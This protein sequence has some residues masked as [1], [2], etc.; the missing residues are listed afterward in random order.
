M[1]KNERVDSQDSNSKQKEEPLN[2]DLKLKKIKQIVFP[3]DNNSRTDETVL[4]L[5]ANTPTEQNI[6]YS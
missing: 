6:N 1:A 2:I 5:E 3:I 4:M